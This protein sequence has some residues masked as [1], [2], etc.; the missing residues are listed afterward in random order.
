[1]FCLTRAGYDQ[2]NR[3]DAKIFID[4]FENRRDESGLSKKEKQI[5]CKIWKMHELFSP[6]NFWYGLFDFIKSADQ[7]EGEVFLKRMVALGILSVE[8]KPEE[9]ASKIHLDVYR[10]KLSDYGRQYLSKNC[11]GFL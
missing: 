8:H 6:G 7:L 10:V 3:Q 11:R 2:L 4:K 1:M 9:D 5:L